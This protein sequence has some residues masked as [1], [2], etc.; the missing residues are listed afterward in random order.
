MS[1]TILFDLDDTLIYCNKYFHHI[2]DRFADQML[3]WFGPTGIERET[4]T[5]KQTEIDIAGVQVLGFKSEHFPQSFVDTYRFFQEYTGRTLSQLEVD[6]LWKLGLSVYDLE[7][8]PYPL[9]DETLESLVRQGH[10]LHLYTGGDPII[11]RR[12]IESMNLERYFD[13]R[14]YVRQHKNTDA[15]ENILFE[16]R[17]DRANTWMIG[18]SIRTDVLPA[19]HCGINAVYLKRETEWTYNVIPIDAQPSGALLTLTEL[20]DVPPAIHNYLKE[21]LMKESG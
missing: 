16:G 10:E 11:Q 21:S 13:D 18:N 15:L 14:I 2:L 20:P 3:E 7:V 1:Q 4:I 8:E 5:A 19:L 17:F 6:D 9:M 12:K